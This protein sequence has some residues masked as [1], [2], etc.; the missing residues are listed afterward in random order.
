M[1]ES[2]V[3]GLS[4]EKHLNHKLRLLRPDMTALCRA[5]FSRVREGDV[6]PDGPVLAVADRVARSLLQMFRPSPQSPAGDDRPC[7]LSVAAVLRSVEGDVVPDLIK[8]L[9][10]LHCIQA[11]V[12]LNDECNERGRYSQLLSNTSHEQLINVSVSMFDLLRQSHVLTTNDGGSSLCN[13]DV[14]QREGHDYGS[15]ERAPST[16][17]TLS[18][19]SSINA[20]DLEE[21]LFIA[22]RA[23]NRLLEASCCSLNDGDGHPAPLQGGVEIFHL[24]RL[25]VRDSAQLTTRFLLFAASMAPYHHNRK[26]LFT[27]FCNVVLVEALK[28]AGLLRRHLHVG[29]TSLRDHDHAG[30]LDGALRALLKVVLFD[31]K[32]VEDMSN[33]RI[34]SGAWVNGDGGRG[35][36]KRRRLPVVASSSSVSSSASSSSSAAEVVSEPSGA[37][38]THSAVAASFHE[39]MIRVLQNELKRIVKG[40]ADAWSAVHVSESLQALLHLYCQRSVEVG[41]SSPPIGLAAAAASNREIGLDGSNSRK[42]VLR[43]LHFAFLLI[44]NVSEASSCRE[45]SREVLKDLCQVCDSDSGSVNKK[46]KSHLAEGTALVN[47]LAASTVRNHVLSAC[48][49][50]LRSSS[51][52]N[53]ESMSRYTLLLHGL[54]TRCIQSCIEYQ[55]LMSQRALV[56]DL[57]ELDRWTQLLCLDLECIRLVGCIDRATVVETNL[58]PVLDTIRPR[59]AVLPDAVGSRLLTGVSEA[60]LDLVKLIV[61][62]HTELR[63]LDK[64]IEELMQQEQQMSLQYTDSLPLVYSREH[65]LDIIFSS[66]EMVGLLVAGFQ[67]APVGQIPVLWSCLARLDSACSC[68]LFDAKY[69]A[70]STSVMICSIVQALTAAQLHSIRSN[71]THAV[72]ERDTDRT[73]D[74]SVATLARIL[75]KLLCTLRGLLCVDDR[76]R[77]QHTQVSSSLLMEV[78]FS[79]VSALLRYMTHSCSVRTAVSLAADLLLPS[80][81]AARTAV[82]VYSMVSRDLL[83]LVRS[84]MSVGGRGFADSVNGTVLLQTLLAITLFDKNISAKTS[85]VKAQDE[86]Q[87]FSSDD[88]L[89]QFVDDFSSDASAD[90]STVLHFLSA[91]MKS[92]HIWTH[93]TSRFKHTT[94]AALFGRF[95]TRIVA[96]DPAADGGVDCLTSVE[97]ICLSLRGPAVRDNCVL[98]SRIADALCCVWEAVG[99]SS[100]LLASSWDGM[101]QHGESIGTVERR[102]TT[103]VAIDALLGDAFASYVQRS[104]PLLRGM[105]GCLRSCLGCI[106]KTHRGDCCLLAVEAVAKLLVLVIR[107]HRVSVY[108]P[109]VLDPL[110]RVIVT[111]SLMPVVVSIMSSDDIRSDGKPSME[112]LLKHLDVVFAVIDLSLA[113][114]NSNQILLRVSPTSYLHQL[115]SILVDTAATYLLYSSSSDDDRLGSDGAELEGAIESFTARLSDMLVLAGQE[116]STP[117]C[118]YLV[119]HLLHTFLSSVQLTDPLTCD[120]RGGAVAAHGHR[121]R[122]YHTRKALLVSLIDQTEQALAIAEGLPGSAAGDHAMKSSAELLAIICS[123]HRN[124]RSSQHDLSPLSIKQSSAMMMIIEA[125]SSRLEA[126]ITR[127]I[128]LLFSPTSVAHELHSSGGWLSLVG[129]IGSEVLGRT[130]TCVSGGRGSDEIEEESSAYVAIDRTKL[131]CL[132]RM[133]LQKA[134]HLSFAD[135]DWLPSVTSL[136]IVA[137]VSPCL[138]MIAETSHSNCDV[139]ELLAVV[140]DSFLLLPMLEHQE[141]YQHAFDLSAGVC[142]DLL[143]YFAQH[144]RRMV[145][146][147]AAAQTKLNSFIEGLMQLTLSHFESSVSCWRGE[148]GESAALRVLQASRTVSTVLYDI[149]VGRDRPSVRRKAS[150]SN[151]SSTGVLRFDLWFDG[152]LRLLSLVLSHAHS[153]GGERLGRVASK[154][155]EDAA[156]A[157]REATDAGR[158]ATVEEIL[159]CALFTLERFVTVSSVCSLPNLNTSVGLLTTLMNLVMSVLLQSDLHNNNNNNN[160]NRDASGRCGTVRTSCFHQF[161]RILFSIASAAVLEK[162]VHFIA[163][164]VVEALSRCASIPKRF[165]DISFPGVFGLFERCAARQK[166]QMFAM[167][168]ARSRLLMTDLHAEFLRSFKFT[169]K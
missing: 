46:R 161:N 9:V 77:C 17:G 2:K 135:D 122:K 94:W 37:S 78:C 84:V 62:L 166:T 58:R 5:Y 35:E 44:E 45:A 24:Q 64:L 28:L 29:T 91:M 110:H 127:A 31:D 156:D 63:L 40:P 54:S 23:M 141:H 165:Q 65:P 4:S 55:A 112:Q 153:W 11:V 26:K 95:F 124:M 142:S 107:S 13:D 144:G 69:A 83:Q 60:K 126:A 18:V 129:T 48:V 114:S 73:V 89:V 136:A 106:E 79:T 150:R 147:T 143:I 49:E 42:H 105:A 168:D 19:Y 7:I 132:L 3:T 99:T 50:C 22:M 36:K 66:D 121:N 15:Y 152:S 145:P 100:P 47:D 82:S 74:D 87:C 159:Q 108:D 130:G 90:D 34:Q 70:V 25:M 59:C 52:P 27:N 116:A 103:V 72:D 128:R 39:E 134:S 10:A 162:H 98:C 43:V 81:G 67:A 146:H 137:Y 119:G 158:E 75:W 76:Y 30:G 115:L 125:S 71:I 38:S 33:I 154:S 163:C 51:I 41:L 104:P 61:S 102:A 118:R 16:I 148:R 101:Q 169:G 86:E 140:R 113:A 32:C 80:G 155:R 6:C 14:D 57:E 160:N 93:L 157:G 151:D 96:S 167:L 8:C 149:V 164:T 117:G 20:A 56:D 1:M 68:A 138:S 133:V 97:D 120:I 109:T 92:V 123:L 111:H 12:Q 53:H 88:Q 139:G 85:A 21:D 131:S